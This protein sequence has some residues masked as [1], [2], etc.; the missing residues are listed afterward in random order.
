MRST[1]VG[2]QYLTASLLVSLLV[3]SIRVA[4]SDGDSPRNSSVPPSPVSPMIL[5]PASVEP[6]P[7][8]VASSSVYE[9]SASSA[10]FTFRT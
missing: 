3:P 10:R 2:A 9:P 1:A 8:V 6:S 7:A 5:A 4:R